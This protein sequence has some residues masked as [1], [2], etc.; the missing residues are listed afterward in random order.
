MAG[1]VYRE[2]ACAAGP[3]DGAHARPCQSSMPEGTASLMPS[4]HGSRCGVIATFVKIVFFL[5][6][7]ITFGFVFSFVPGATPKNPA[8]GLMA[9][10][11]PSEPTCIQAISSPT[12][13][14]R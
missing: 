9:C 11:Y 8:S 12:V 10:K 4:H 1:T 13:H 6:A 7:I 14:T 2:L 5:S 3:L